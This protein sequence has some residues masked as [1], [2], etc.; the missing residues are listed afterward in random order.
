[1]RIAGGEFCGRTL[2]VPRS[3]ALRPTQD[4]VREALFS[5]LQ[6]E[7][8]GADF[9]E[10]AAEVFLELIDIV[11]AARLAYIY[12]MIRNLLAVNNIVGKV[13]TRTDIHATVYLTAV[14]ADNLSVEFG[15]KF[16]SQGCF[17]RCGRSKNSNHIHSAKIIFF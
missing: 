15:S 8:A 6:C 3:E 2:F 5:I 12:K 10:R 14:G 1:M 9:L 4:R 13:L 17:S 16:G 11:S 7:I